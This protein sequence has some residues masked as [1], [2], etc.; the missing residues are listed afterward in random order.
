MFKFYTVIKL[1]RK[2]KKKFS[3]LNYV[4]ERCL[5]PV[6]MIQVFSELRP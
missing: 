3:S 4:T 1:C 2:I 5:R 6:V